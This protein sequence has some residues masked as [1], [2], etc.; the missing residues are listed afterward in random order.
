MNTVGIKAVAFD[1]DGTLYSTPRLYARVAGFGIRNLRLLAA[2][3]EVRHAIH[4]KAAD[5]A[6]RRHHQHRVRVLEFRAGRVGSCTHA[7]AERAP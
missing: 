4:A 3:S 5:P 6:A 2:F 7:L 1:V